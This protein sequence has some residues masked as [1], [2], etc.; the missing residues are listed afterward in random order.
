MP[1]Y[2]QPFFKA[3]RGTWYV[4]LRG[5]QF[6]LGTDRDK[7]FRR[8]HELMTASEKRPNGV[9]VDDA[10]TVISLIDEF[11][12]SLSK[13]AEP[14]TFEWYQR[15]LQ[16][17][18]NGLPASLTVAQII[19]RH[20]T[21]I[22]EQHGTWSAATKHSFARAAKRPFQWAEDEGIIPK[23]PLRKLKKPTP[24][25][26]EVVI[27]TEVY[28]TILAA[29]ESD[30]GRDL[31]TLAWET[32][33]RPQELVALETRHLDFTRERAVFP[34]A[35]AKGKK[36]P[37]IIVFTPTALAICRKLS[38]RFPTGPLLRT[39][40]NI[41]WR[42]N[43]ISHLFGR[44]QLVTGRTRATPKLV[45]PEKPQRFNALDYSS[46]ISL[47]QAAKQQKK[48]LVV[49]RLECERRHRSLAKRY[50]LYHFRH[51]FATR[52]IHN[53]VDPLTV[54]TLLGHRDPSMLAK[55]YAHVAQ[56][57]EYLIR[58]VRKASASIKVTA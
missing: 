58:S 19:P 12:D 37:R 48:L 1:H 16:H 22:L 49:H 25:H 31:I 52:A 26:R 3:T 10:S 54:G 56:D 41:G 44:I 23:N 17:L 30:A 13:S 33:A 40:D 27:S 15:H 46:P 2:P 42:R 45:L 35:E 29:C 28:R 11:L 34:P 51:A 32:G 38:I 53:G 21:K 7:A 24:G 18:V 47:A 9:P 39:K 4:Q 8:Y 50:T 5:R 20:V 57:T 14:R 55:V 43:A 36:L 6:N